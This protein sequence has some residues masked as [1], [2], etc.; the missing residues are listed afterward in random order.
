MALAASARVTTEQE[1][2]LPLA[3]LA[4]MVV[5]GDADEDVVGEAAGETAVDVPLDVLG[6]D[7]PHP[8]HRTAA[9]TTTASPAAPLRRAIPHPG[10]T[11]RRYVP[12]KPTPR[13]DLAPLGV[14]R[15]KVL[16]V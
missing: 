2:N 5:V 13:Q 11:W 16:A 15:A 8:T 14:R 1:S 4:A 3:V 7:E 12:D 6:E 10:P 9:D